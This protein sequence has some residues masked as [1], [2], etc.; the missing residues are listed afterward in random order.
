MIDYKFKV[1]VEVGLKESTFLQFLDSEKA[2]DMEIPYRTVKDIARYRDIESIDE[3]PP[4]ILKA[5]KWYIQTCIDL[6]SPIVWHS[7]IDVYL[8]LDIDELNFKPG[9]F[10]DYIHR[11]IEEYEGLTIK[12][13]ICSKDAYS[14]L[15]K[16]FGD[17]FCMDLATEGLIWGDMKM[18]RALFRDILKY[19]PENMQKVLSFID[20][21]E[22]A[23]NPVNKKIQEFQEFIENTPIEAKHLLDL[24]NEE[25][26]QK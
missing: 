10:L 12:T 15:H 21:I 6:G 11:L 23:W 24:L 17:T 20:E 2:Y 16:G 26:E 1:T 8:D 22:A 19:S 25:E 3:L 4:E 9:E 13:A 18:Y 7:I 5:L 14:E